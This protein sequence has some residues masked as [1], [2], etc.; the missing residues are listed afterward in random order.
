MAINVQRRAFIGALGVAA[1]WPLAGRA[2]HNDGM[3]R[4]GALMNLAERDPE[5]QLR[6]G[7]LREGLAKLGWM[8]GRE[9]KFEYRWAGG[10][11]ERARAYAV[12]LVRLKP[13]VIFAGTTFSMAALQHETSSVP[14]VFAQVADPVGAGFVPSL[15][16]P[17]GNITGFAQFEYAIGAKWL[18]LLKQISPQ[19]TRVGDHLRSGRSRSQGILTRD[20]GRRSINWDAGVHSL[21]A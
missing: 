15:A 17:G 10:D 4:I 19:V 12:E 16:R 2:Q 3:R 7:A 20:R 5:G 14:V 8:E 18:E 6:I 21:C 9:V 13:D 1:A 11:P